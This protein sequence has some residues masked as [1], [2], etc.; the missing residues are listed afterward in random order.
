MLVSLNSHVVE[1]QRICHCFSGCEA[2]CFSCHHDCWNLYGHRICSLVVSLRDA[3]DIRTWAIIF[4]ELF[5]SHI[6]NSLDYYRLDV[7]N[8]N[9]YTICAAF[10]NSMQI[11]C[12]SFLESRNLSFRSKLLSCPVRTA[13]PSPHMCR[14]AVFTP[15]RV[16]RTILF[17]MSYTSTQHWTL[18]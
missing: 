3:G 14:N 7:N 13:S 11:F 16:G 15:S 4:V 5:Q 8:C 18:S 17:T 2:F 6:M 9:A 10:S 12:Q 1:I